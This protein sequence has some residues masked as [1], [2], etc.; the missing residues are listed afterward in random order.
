MAVTLPQ[1][2]VLSTNTLAR[3]VMETFVIES[4]VLDRIPLMTIQGN[5][6]AYTKE[7]TLPGVAFRSRR[8]RC[9]W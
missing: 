6:Y 3:G 4:S 1:A 7:L 5:A 9:C 8:S 2:A